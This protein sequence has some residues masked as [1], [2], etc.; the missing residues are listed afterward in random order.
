MKPKGDKGSGP[1]SR[2]RS[3]TEQLGF[4]DVRQNFEHPDIQKGR[5]LSAHVLYK[6]TKHARLKHGLRQKRIFSTCVCSGNNK[7]KASLSN[8]STAQFH[9]QIRCS[10][11]ARILTVLRA[12][13]RGFY[14]GF[15]LRGRVQG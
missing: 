12:I 4:S 10:W 15:C 3:T 5:P 14:E 11:L 2:S 13:Y 7:A 9:Y 6:M 1:L 8:V